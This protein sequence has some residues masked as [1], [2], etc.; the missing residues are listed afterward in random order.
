MDCKEKSVSYHT[1]SGQREEIQGIKKKIKLRLI[2]TNQLG[3]RIS[4][5]SQIYV[6]QVGYSID[7]N[8]M[9]SLENIPVIQD[10]VD[11]FPESIL[12]LPPR[13]DIDFTIELMPG[14]APVLK[15]PYPM[16]IPKLTKLRIQPQELLDK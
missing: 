5:G 7:I 9:T 16:S 13:R 11:V 10:F 14:V 1:E 8:K 15:A 3:R 6:F 12:G 2:S 4:K